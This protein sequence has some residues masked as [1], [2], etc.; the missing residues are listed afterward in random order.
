MRARG[1]NRGGRV[2][3]F[4]ASPRRL[5]TG[6]WL[7]PQAGRGNYRMSGEH[8][9]VFLTTEAMPH[10]TILA[11]A[12][13]EGWHVYEVEPDGPVWD[14]S[15]GD[16]VARRAQIVRYVGSAR[17]LSERRVQRKVRRAERAGNTEEA[18]R[19]KSEPYGE[20]GSHARPQVP[21]AAQR[22]QW[23]E[24][25]ERSAEPLPAHEIAEM[26]RTAY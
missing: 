11:K 13:R 3:Y 19:I 1:K 8:E 5:K 14:G 10:F 24:A 15:W 2:R 21:L 26:S 25:M 20:T 23:V 12:R 18:K 22:R 7:S 17:G 16:R 6:T 9:G 4:H